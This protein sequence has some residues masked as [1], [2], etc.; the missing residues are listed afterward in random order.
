MGPSYCGT[1]MCRIVFCCTFLLTSLG[2]LMVFAS[3]FFFSCLSLSLVGRGSTKHQT[4]RV[5]NSCCFCPRYKFQKR[6]QVTSLAVQLPLETK[7]PR[8]RGAPRLRGPEVPASIASLI[9]KNASRVLAC[10][11]HAAVTAVVLCSVKETKL[12]IKP[13]KPSVFT[14]HHSL[15]DPVA[16][17]GW[18][19]LKPFLHLH[20]HSDSASPGPHRK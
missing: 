13:N 10:S 15:G 11:C 16:I 5:L 9:F 6:L 2:S 19:P 4:G 20:R 7:N 12:N 18:G 14:V 1:A 17:R 3:S 8:P